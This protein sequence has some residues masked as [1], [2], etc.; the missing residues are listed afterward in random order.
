MPLAGK[1]KGSQVSL[2]QEAFYFISTEVML[3]VMEGYHD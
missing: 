2:E 3:Q 1:L